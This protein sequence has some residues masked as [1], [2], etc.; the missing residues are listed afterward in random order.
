MFGH[1]DQLS[2][3]ATGFRTHNQEPPRREKVQTIGGAGLQV[4]RGNKGTG[5]WGINES[6]SDSTGKA[7]R[8][9][10]KLPTG[11]PEIL[12]AEEPTSYGHPREA[13]ATTE[14][15]EDSEG[16]I[17]GTQG[18]TGTPELRRLPERKGLLCQILNGQPTQG[19]NRPRLQIAPLMISHACHW[20]MLSH[21]CASS[22][23]YSLQ[24]TIAS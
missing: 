24:L 10:K 14:P 11:Q 3:V 12:P 4:A 15:P 21:S 6:V 5:G 23:A 20:S 22:C 1:R 2:D 8:S 18:T 7:N 16:L 19:M 17:T 9:G 13:T